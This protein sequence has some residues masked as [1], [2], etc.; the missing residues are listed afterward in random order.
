MKVLITTGITED[1]GDER[2]SSLEIKTPK[3]RVCFHEMEPEDAYLHR[4]L[5]DAYSIEDM[6]QEAFEAGQNGEK[7]EFERKTEY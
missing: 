2:E 5:S 3:N 7:L 1:C 4:C 6:I